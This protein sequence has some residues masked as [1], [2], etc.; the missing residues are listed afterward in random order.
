M[1]A[2]RRKNAKRERQMKLPRQQA[3]ATL[4]N[5]FAGLLAQAGPDLRNG[6]KSQ[7]GWTLLGHLRSRLPLMNY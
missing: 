6:A 5:Q 2:K 3:F 1:A 7:L 4:S